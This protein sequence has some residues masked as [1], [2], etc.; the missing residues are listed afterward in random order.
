MKIT[1][2]KNKQLQFDNKGF[3]VIIL[4]KEKKKIIVE[5][6]LNKEKEKGMT[7][8]LNKIIEGTNAEE[9]CHTIIREGLVSRT[10]HAAY[11]GRELQ[12]AETALKNN[13][14]YEQ[15]E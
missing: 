14:P 8:K 2:E 9:L 1:A 15:D 7:G 12:K 4:D 11:L 10:D 3:F 5:H 13:L 6:Y